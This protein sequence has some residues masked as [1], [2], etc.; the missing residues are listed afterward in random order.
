MAFSLI[1]A[2]V[3]N[4]RPIYHKNFLRTVFL[5]IQRTVFHIY[6][7]YYLGSARAVH[8]ERTQHF[9]NCQVAF[10]PWCERYQHGAAAYHPFG[11]YYVFW[12][13]WRTVRACSYESSRNFSDESYGSFTGSDGCSL[14]H[15]LFFL[16]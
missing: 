8:G 16:Q 1:L 15:A 4:T 7:E 10:L 11:E 13:I 6:C 9:S 5:Y 2:N 3:K 12:R 14:D